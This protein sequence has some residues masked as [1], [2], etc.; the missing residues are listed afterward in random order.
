MKQRG[1]VLRHRVSPYQITVRRFATDPA[2]QCA[3]RSQR[4]QRHEHHPGHPRRRA[5]STDIGRPGYAR[6]EGHPGDIAKSLEGNWREELLFVL[7]QHLELYQIY[8]EKITDCD[9][10]CGN[11]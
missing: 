3:E 7:R 9:L 11:I 2:Q 1:P 8:Q 5:R 4:R 6:S 10:Q